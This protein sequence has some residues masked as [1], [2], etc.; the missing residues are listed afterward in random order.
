MLSC[1]WGCENRNAAH[2][3]HKPVVPNSDWAGHSKSSTPHDGLVATTLNGL[4]VFGC[5]TPYM[6]IKFETY[7]IEF[8]CDSGKSAGGIICCMLPVLCTSV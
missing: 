4:L 2:M 7:C 6:R 8:M 3:L 1:A 5:I